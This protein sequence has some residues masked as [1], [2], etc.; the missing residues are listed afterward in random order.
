M[1]LRSLKWFSLFSFFGE[2]QGFCDESSE[3]NER[4]CLTICP[5]CY[6]GGDVIVNASLLYWNARINGMEYAARTTTCLIDN[7]PPKIV[8]TTFEKFEPHHKWDPG[9]RVG[10]GYQSCDC[11][12]NLFLKGTYFQTIAKGRAKT[13]PSNNDEVSVNMYPLVYPFLVGGSTERASARWKLDFGLVDLL[14]GGRFT[15]WSCVTLMPNFGLR[16]V[17]IS[18]SYKVRYRDSSFTIVIPPSTFINLVNP[19]AAV[20]FH[21]RYRA[22]GFKGGI[23]FETHLSRHFNLFGGAGASL[24]YGSSHVKERA[25][26]AT[27]DNEQFLVDVTTITKT[28]IMRLSGNLESEL[29]VS[30]KTDYKRVGVDFGLSYFFSLWF[31]QW[32]FSDLFFTVPPVPGITFTSFLNPPVI[33]RH[34]R[35]LMLHGLVANLQFSF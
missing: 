29:G 16:A 10:I 2:M 13:T 28:R 17:Y 30:Y 3:K 7:D 6:Q 12:W 23:D 19:S 18:Q 34:H 14:G 8:E 22:Y 1:K 5:E 27:T 9:V 26:G 15:P 24:V 21:S 35:N 33:Q 25:H 4:K 20:N 32:D 31:D 11:R